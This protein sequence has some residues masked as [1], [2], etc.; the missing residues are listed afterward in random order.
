MEKPAIEGGKPTRE[1]YLV[2]GK[3]YIQEEEINEVAKVLRSGWIGTGP[4]VRKF[5]NLFKD[6]IGCKHAIALNSCT[7]ALHLTLLSNDIGKG[8]EIITTS[9]TFAATVNVIENVNATPVFVDI[10]NNSYNIDAEKIKEAINSKTKAIIPVHIGGLPCEMEKIYKLAKEHNLIVIEDAAHALG[11]KYKSKK[12]GSFGNPTCFSLSPTKNITAIE[13]G[14]VCSDDGDFCQILRISSQY[15]L[16]QNAWQRYH[17]ERK[18]TYEIIL[19]GYKYNLTDVNAA[20]GIQ[21]L[22]RIDKTIEIKQKYAEMYSKEFENYELVELPPNKKERTHVWNYY[23]I[24]LRLDKLKILRTDFIN[25]LHLENIGT[26]IHYRAIHQQYYYKNKYKFKH[27]LF[28]R[29]EFVSERVVSLPL[30]TS[31]SDEDLL[32]VVNAVKKIL[33]YYAK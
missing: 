23:S 2:F 29:T 17:K 6:Y 25:A 9:M 15:G 13:G 27:N 16:N 32:D 30:Q 33:N 18:D 28:K 7:A 19:P 3:P 10:E 24:L 14:F 8:D 26:G 11:A 4:L 31:M 21:Q 20:V 1:N 5:E 22:K 12:I